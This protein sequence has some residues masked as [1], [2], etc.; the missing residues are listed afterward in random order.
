MTTIKCDMC[1]CDFNNKNGICELKEVKL[2][3]KGCK[4]NLYKESMLY[5]DNYKKQKIEHIITEVENKNEELKDRVRELEAPEELLKF[6][7]IIGLFKEE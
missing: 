2:D 1:I 5:C 4:D 7:D 3:M 6:K